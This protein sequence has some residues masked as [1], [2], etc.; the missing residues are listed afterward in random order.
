MKNLSNLNIGKVLSKEELTMIKGG[1]MLDCNCGGQWF[2]MSC[3]S[4]AECSQ[5]A[6][7]SCHNG[8]VYCLQHREG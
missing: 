4:T 5:M 1:T 6:I 2:T 8:N 3:D 7:D